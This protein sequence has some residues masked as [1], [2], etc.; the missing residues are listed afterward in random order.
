[1]STERTEPERRTRR[2]QRRLREED[3]DAVVLSKGIDM[4]YF[5]GFFT[6]PQKRPLFL[7]VPAG[8]DPQFFI[9]DPYHEAVSTDAWVDEIAIW[10]D[11]E[12]PTDVL[13]AVVAD[14]GLAEAGTVLVDETMW[15]MYLLMLTE[16]IDADFGVVTDLV[17]EQRMQKSEEELDSFREA[18]AITDEVYDEM[19]EFDAVGLTENQ[20]AA[21]VEYRLRRK[22]AE[23]GS[24][25]I[26]GGP[27]SAKPPHAK[28]GREIRAGEPVI[29]DLGCAVDGYL[30]DQSR[31]IVFEGD[32]PEGFEDAFAVVREAQE[33]A[34]DAIEPGMQASEVDAVARG[35]IAD[36]GYEGRFLHVTGHGLGL[37]IHEPPYLM[38]GTYLDGGNEIDLAEGMVLTVEPGIY[39][40]DWG[41]RIEDDV[42]VTAGG[43]ERVTATDHGWEPDPVA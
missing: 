5:S 14:L 30:S 41:I 33:A 2:L 17:M 13:Q 40:D 7:F 21:E 3:V 28:S 23:V 12:D 35:V 24:I 16:A 39:L 38:S 11:D 43:C 15:G 25:Q 9:P 8:G 29:L 37:G 22:G 26:A 1:M 32:P 36:A 31:T 6:R 27:N 10:E 4:G 19:R 20:V 42:I 18:V 34:I